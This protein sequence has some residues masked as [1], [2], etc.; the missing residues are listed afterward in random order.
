MRTPDGRDRTFRVYVPAS[1]DGGDR[2]VPLLVAL[3]GG[4]GWGAQFERNLGRDG[5]AEANGFIVVYPDGFNAGT[6]ARP[7]RTWN[8]G[9]CCGPAARLDVDD[10]G[11]IELLIDRLAHDYLIDADQVVATG[12]SNADI[13]ATTWGPCRDGTEVAF[14]ADAG[15]SHAWMRHTTGGSGLTGPPYEGLDS[16]LVIWDFLS[17]HLGG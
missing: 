9:A 15:A 7:L 13:T 10:V 12:H 8:G 2:A 14:V 3:H 6:D 11:F 5:L 16:S 17:H 1:V 4:L